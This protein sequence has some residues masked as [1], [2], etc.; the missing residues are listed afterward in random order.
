MRAIATYGVAWSV[1]LCVCLL[2]TFFS[3]AFSA[4]PSEMPFVGLTQ[5]G[6]RNHVLDGFQ[7]PE[8]KT[9]IWGSS[10]PFQSTG[11]IWCGVRIVS[12][13]TMNKDEY[14]KGVIQS[15]ITAATR[16]ALRSFVK[17]F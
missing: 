10:K 17:I 3:P 9:Q 16:H 1:G 2:A 8:G 4:E 15:S 13:I 14:I 12:T 7:I 11:S 6:P 5:V